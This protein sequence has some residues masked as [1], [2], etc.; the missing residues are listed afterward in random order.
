MI[1]LIVCIFIHRKNIIRFVKLPCSNKNT[2]LRHNDLMFV[3]ELR[4]ML[5][6]FKEKCFIKILRQ[7][8][9]WGG[10]R[11]GLLVRL[12]IFYGKSYIASHLLIKGRKHF[13]ESVMVSV[14]VSKAGKTSV[15]FID[16]TT[17]EPRQMQ[18][19]TAKLCSSDVF[20]RRFVRSPTIISCFNRTAH[21]LIERSQ[22]SSSC[23]VPC[24]ISSKCMATKQPGLNL[25]DYAVCEA[26]QQSVYR[27]S[28]SS[29]Q[30]GRSRGQSAHL[31][32]ES[33]GQ[34]IINK[35]IDQWRDRLKGSSS[36][37][38]WTH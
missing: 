17:K 37:E 22:L 24:R 4:T 31:L 35:S 33:L 29:F 36:N 5:F 9:G 34:Q 18:V 38:R 28:H 27:K 8:N 26:L 14:A 2:M 23:S 32:E 20:S 16:N 12:T 13:S 21:H 15:N 10:K 30:P 1:I 19:T 7:E 25:V 3:Y 6:T 11:N